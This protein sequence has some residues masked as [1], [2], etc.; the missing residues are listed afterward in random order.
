MDL[1]LALGQPSVTR[2]LDEMTDQDLDGW[3]AYARKHGLPQRRQE[4]Y[5]AQVAQAH[6]GGKLEAYLLGSAKP[7]VEE[8]TDS[9]EQFVTDLDSKAVHVVRMPKKER[10]WRAA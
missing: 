1:A 2:M 4:L 5:L 3:V 7:K 9:A 10:P 6:G 8:V